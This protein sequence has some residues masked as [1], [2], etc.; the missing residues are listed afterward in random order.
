MLVQR[1]RRTGARQM[2]GLGVLGFR[3]C[4]AANPGVKERARYSEWHAMESSSCPLPCSDYE[5]LSHRFAVA[6]PVMV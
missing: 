1:P 4:V 5:M 6:A 3:G 2:R